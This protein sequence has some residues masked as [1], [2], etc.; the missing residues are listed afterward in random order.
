[1]G[2]IVSRRYALGLAIVGGLTSGLGT[3][4]HGQLSPTT[5]KSAQKQETSA[6][7]TRPKIYE[8]DEVKKSHRSAGCTSSPG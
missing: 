1:M 3:R 4:M 5:S 8:D 7:R 6:N 2:L